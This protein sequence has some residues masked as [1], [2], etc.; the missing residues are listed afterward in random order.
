MIVLFSY[1]WLNALYFVQEKLHLIVLEKVMLQ[2]LVHILLLNI[3]F[4]EIS[5]ITHFCRILSKYCDRYE[6]NSLNILPEWKKIYAE[7]FV[8]TQKCIWMTFL[9]WKRITKTSHYWG[10]QQLL[11]DFYS[12]QN[13]KCILHCWMSNNFSMRKKPTQS[14]NWNLD[15]VLILNNRKN[16]NNITATNKCSVCVVHNLKYWCVAVLNL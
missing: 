7:E 16:E 6:C 4:Y 2:D 5:F 14:K 3:S 1:A 15:D 12:H 13:I 8:F 9:V 10:S 11:G